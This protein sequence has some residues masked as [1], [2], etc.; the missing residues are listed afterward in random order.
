VHD[1]AHVPVNQVLFQPKC[2]VS[3]MGTN[4]TRVAARPS[5]VWDNTKE[6]YPDE[7]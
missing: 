4:G 7:A 2:A 5:F 3:C 6:G 1:L